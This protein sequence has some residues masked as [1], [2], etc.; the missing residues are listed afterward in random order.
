MRNY[1]R[2]Q[3]DAISDPE[4]ISTKYLIGKNLYFEVQLALAEQQS[5]DPSR[6]SSSG[7]STDAGLNQ[8]ILIYGGGG[9]SGGSFGCP[10]ENENVWVNNGD[11]IPMPIPARALLRDSQIWTLY[12]PLSRE[13]DALEYAELIENVGIYRM[14][15]K[16]GSSKLVSESHSIITNTQD[17]G[18][19]PMMKHWMKYSNSEVVSMELS[20]RNIFSDE[21]KQIQFVRPGN[22]IKIHLKT[23]HIYISGHS[24]EYVSLDHNLKPLPEV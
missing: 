14:T 13:F 6:S 2:N 7:P 10:E 17:L 15:T 8:V 22:V 4:L 9:G 24:D 20:S 21:I 1:F 16:L 19:T 12:N 23:G 18:G 3:D 5:T 11:G